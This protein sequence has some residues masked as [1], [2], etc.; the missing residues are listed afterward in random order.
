MSG[1]DQW[2]YWM[3]A[4][5]GQFG[6]V[7]ETYPESGYWRHGQTGAAVAIWRE[8]GMFTMM[9]D[10]DYVTD[11]KAQGKIWMACAKHP[12]S[13]DHFEAR[14]AT[15]MWPVEPTGVAKIVTDALARAGREPD[16][17][18]GPGDNSG[19]PAEFLRMKAEA[20]AEIAKAEPYIRDHA[21]TAKD[22]ADLTMDWGKRLTTMANDMKAKRLAETQPLR[23]QID[24][25]NARWTALEGVTRTS[26]GELCA[27]AEAWGKQ[28][29]DRLYKEEQERAAKARE[30][31]LAEAKRLAE[32]ETERRRQAAA[33]AE[34]TGEPAPQFNLAEP[35]VPEPVPQPV[36]VAPKLMLGTGRGGK[37]TGVSVNKAPETATVIDLAAAAAYFAKQSH[38]DLVALIQKLSD[39]AI[40]S[41]VEIPGI[42]FSWQSNKE[43]V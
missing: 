22:D 41:R 40:K 7:R 1:Q 11:T 5:E 25:I 33:E 43:S 32:E 3:T 37:R 12:V 8:D 2:T 14:C 31:Q 38:P 35:V 13:Y 24:T 18:A 4:R 30:A 28:E 23:E 34:A 27:K 9:V 39:R 42:R 15:G 17:P 6:P 10:N 20:E 16:A 26:G 36:V 19:L 29:A 21:I